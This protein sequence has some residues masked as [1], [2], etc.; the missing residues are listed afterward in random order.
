MRQGLFRLLISIVMVLGLGAASLAYA[1]GPC[2]PQMQSQTLSPTVL[3]DCAQGFLRT[4]QG[5]IPCGKMRAGCV[6]A[7]SCFSN[8]GLT[9]PEIGLP[10]HDRSDCGER[11]MR[12]SLLRGISVAPLLHPPA[13]NS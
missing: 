5:R 10:L 6:T 4:E 12:N 8:I 9:A 1:S 13:F 7:A 11:T 3:S 2:L